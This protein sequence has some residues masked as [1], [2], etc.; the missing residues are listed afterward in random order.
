[1]RKELSKLSTYQKKS[2]LLIFLGVFLMQFTFAQRNISGTITSASDKTPLSG[3]S[4]IVKGTTNGITT[5]TNGKFFLNV[6]AGATLV[7]SFI[8]MRTKEI[9]VEDQTVINL[10]L[11]EDVFGLAEV[12]VTGYGTMKKS[13][14][15]GALSSVR[16]KDLEDQPITRVDQAL[17]GRAAGVMVMNNAGSPGGDVSIRIRG[18]NSL[19]GGNNPLCVVDGFVGANFNDIN[20]NDIESIEVL[21]DASGTALYGSRGANGVILI[22]TK[23]GSDKKPVVEFSSRVSTSKVLN[24]YDLLGAADFAKVVNERQAALGNNP[25]FTQEEI[26]E[27]SRSGGTNWQNEILRTGISQDYQLSVAGGN[28][29]TTYRLSSQYLKEDGVIKNSFF[30]RYSLRSNI[31]SKVSEKLSVGL[32]MSFLQRENLNTFGSRGKNSP[33]TQALSWAPTTNVYDENGQYIVSDPVGS[34]AYNPVAII[35]DERRFTNTALNALGKF[36]YKIIEGLTLDISLGT[37]LLFGRGKLFEG[38][39][40]TSNNPSA[41][42]GSID[43]RN[44]INTNILN[45]TKK[46]NDI[47]SLNVTAVFENQTSV[48]ETVTAKASGLL[49]PAMGADNLSLS[50]VQTNTTDYSEYAIL[51]YLG[52]INYGLMD[53]YLLTVTFRRDG[54]S[55][56][57]EG[58]KWS[59][60]PSAAI[61][62]RLS[63]ESFIKNLNLFDQLKLRASWGITGNQAVSPYG[64]LPTF[65]TEN[66]YGGTA[67]GSVSTTGGVVPA[68]LATFATNPDLKWEET[69]A[70][71]FGLD[72]GIFENRLSITADYYK[73][74]TNDLLMGV[75]VPGILG[76]GVKIDNVGTMENSGLEVAVKGIVGN[77]SGLQWES[78]FNAS[79]NHNEIKSIKG[80]E[81]ED[82]MIADASDVGAAMTLD[83]EFVIKP[84]YGLG[85]FWGL[86]YIG[87]WKPEEAVEAA[88]FSKVPGDSKYEDLDGNHIIDGND[89]KIIGNGMPKTILGWNNTLT[90]KGFSLNIFMQAVLGFD[91]LNVA[92]GATL[93]GAFDARQFTSTEIYDRYIPGVNETSDIPAFS[94]TNEIYISSTRFLEK[95]DFVRLKNLNLTYELPIHSSSNIGLSVYVGSTNLLTITNYKGIDPE[96]SSSTSGS[97]VSQSIDY[98]VYPN[99][100]SFYGGL[101]LK[102]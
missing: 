47:H 78:S 43:T 38:A 91:K 52:R 65:N 39:A 100:R 42:R 40:T 45:Y 35:N 74:E 87:T 55:V 53:K 77:V 4:V 92:H 64:T 16:S 84:G 41:T 15:T 69:T 18:A 7:V 8:G 59:T 99:T 5:D 81:G 14:L 19:I 27:Y 22:T 54:S 49:V 2:V 68:I 1:M 34:T 72:I 57:A 46:F 85:S 32:N 23:K 76:G 17:Q 102:F 66:V 11:E 90:Y 73:K 20:P 6:P 58:N 88:L 75:P 97:D 71:D 12:V 62:W 44:L 61:A 101:V 30:K 28:D 9:K 79:F 63:E 36:N 95:G 3:V 51:S 13:D 50:G 93:K 94:S 96:A 21:K 82:D 25:R 31:V 24:T 10:S 60:F 89:A 48:T 29:K 67:Y 83:P 26:D 98:G 70:I 37:D 80:L 86:N 33:L 56:F